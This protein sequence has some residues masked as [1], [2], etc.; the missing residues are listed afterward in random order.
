MQKM[1]R[2]YEPWISGKVSEPSPKPGADTPNDTLNGFERQEPLGDRGHHANTKRQRER[3]RQG[4]R[5]ERETNTQ[6][7]IVVHDGKSVAAA[8]DN[9]GKQTSL[10]VALM[11]E[12]I[13]TAQTTRDETGRI[14]AAQACL[15]SF[16]SG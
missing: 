15:D 4:R 13:A 14:S 12:Y 5:K 6:D 11:Y 7:T 3:N 8:S 9:S 16:E 1:P 10:D 2:I